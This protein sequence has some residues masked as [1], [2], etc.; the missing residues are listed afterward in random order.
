MSLNID[1][2]GTWHNSQATICPLTRSTSVNC[3][4]DSFRMMRLCA[5]AGVG[6][7]IRVGGLAVEM[8]AWGRMPTVRVN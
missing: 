2:Q 4:T 6:K 3:M 5:L 1:Q 8:A 7:K